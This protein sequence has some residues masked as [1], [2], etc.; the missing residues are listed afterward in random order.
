MKRR[1]AQGLEAVVKAPSALDADE[2]A[3]WHGFMAAT[4]ALGRAFLA[5]R[6]A[7][8]CEAAQGRVSVAVLRDAA[9]PCGFLAFQF[10]SAWHQAMAVAEPAGGALAD[11]AGLVAR[12]GFRIAPEALLRLCGLGSL[13]VRQLSPGQE[14]FGLSSAPARI[15]HVIDVAGGAQAY[16]DAL[17]ARDRAFFLDTER[18]ARRLAK[19][20]GEVAY[21]TTA[22]PSPAEVEE[23]IAAKRA[24]Y[25]RTEAG[26]PLAPAQARRLLLHLAREG[27]PECRMVLSRLSAGG[28]VL[29]RHL[30]LMHAGTLSYWFPVYD[31]Q[32]RK[33][34]P[35]RMLLWHTIRDAGALGIA[36][37]DRGGGDSQAKRDFSTGTVT[38]G[39][40]QYAAS[41]PRGAIARLAQSVAWRLGW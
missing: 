3:A 22:D 28:R 6:F 40:A 1:T 34:S 29:A 8:A 39:V 12:P 17:A 21:G 27:V 10:A 7:Q 20:Y 24:Q 36:L 11:H 23:V 13:F 33:V 41:G 18:R 14:A 26:D 16:F 32:A 25:D 38:F 4:P 9:G 35:G 31:P 2:I 37:I 30:G 5:P 15:G 19:E